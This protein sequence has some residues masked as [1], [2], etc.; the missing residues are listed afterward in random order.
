MH[1][2]PIHKILIVDD[3]L[4]DRF[5][6]QRA[7]KKALTNS[8]SINL[9]ANGDEAIAYMM[10]EGEF[11]ARDKYPFPTLVISDLHM[12]P[13]D[14]L[15]VLEF[16]QANRGLFVVP[17]IIFSSSDDD[18][19][20]R[21]A[22]ALGASAYHHKPITCHGM[23]EMML[24]IIHYWGTTEISPTDRA[25]RILPTVSRGRAGQRYSQPP[26]GAPIQRLPPAV[27]R[28]APDPGE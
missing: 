21:A 2:S 16:M 20:V 23:E 4:D 8:S 5:L 12:S 26:A 13:G 14:G 27:E 22:Y 19:D 10:G 18:D 3:D 15:D 24:D 6:S 7:L 17:R 9:A 11:L 1:R 28:P 25:G